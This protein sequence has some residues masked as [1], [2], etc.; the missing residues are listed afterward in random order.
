MDYELRTMKRLTSRFRDLKL[1]LIWT[2]NRELRGNL[3]T[4]WVTRKRTSY[5]KRLHT[6]NLQTNVSVFQVARYNN[7]L[8]FI[9]KF[10]VICGHWWIYTQVNTTHARDILR[11][12]G[13]RLLRERVSVT[14]SILQC[15]IMHVDQYESLLKKPLSWGI[16]QG[17]STMQQNS[18]MN[19]FRK[20]KKFRGLRVK[21]PSN[22]EE[23]T[24][25]DK[26][27]DKVVGLSVF[28][29]STFWFRTIPTEERPKFQHHSFKNRCSKFCSSY[30]KCFERPSGYRS[31]ISPEWRVC[32]FEEGNSN[33][34]KHKSCREEGHEESKV[35]DS[36]S[37]QR[38][39][40]SCDK[41]VRIWG[42]STCSS[43]RRP[44]Q[45]TA[46]DPTLTYERNLTRFQLQ[47]LP[48]KSY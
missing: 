44:I 16:W 14:R 29:L 3:N 36:T 18:Y 39:C 47:L 2:T 8:T 40:D 5:C 25:Y 13:L 10:F 1:S 17:S 19:G 46:K 26:A 33:L 38:T 22:T 24:S 37:W 4:Q 31:W 12:T 11:N 45:A 9:V 23:N 15:H 41:P 35:D 30:W 27:V 7:H 34:C 32:C 6:R 48:D 43:W 20:V 28:Q 21:T 42:E